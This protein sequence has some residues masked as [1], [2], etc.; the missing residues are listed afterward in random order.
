MDM[1]A[2]SAS[3]TSSLRLKDPA[4]VPASPEI[5]ANASSKLVAGPTTGRLNFSKIFLL[6][7]KG[8]YHTAKYAIL[9]SQLWQLPNHLN[10]AIRMKEVAKLGNAKHI[11]FSAITGFTLTALIRAI[12]R[13]AAKRLP[14][15][16]KN[17]GR[18]LTG[19]ISTT[20]AV[21][22][23][24]FGV[25]RSIGRALTGRA[26]VEHVFNTVRFYIIVVPVAM[27]AMHFNGALQKAIVEAYGSLKNRIKQFGT[28]LFKA[29]STGPTKLEM[30]LSDALPLP[31]APAVLP[32][33]LPK[34]HP[35]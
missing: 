14:A 9:G 35:T 20:M 15:S 16:A 12:D 31:P 10:R 13:Q 33:A 19:I 23:Y 32:G 4:I 3:S 11:F 2:P 27:A 6:T 34:A 8:G 7:L 17:P 22:L 18:F 5:N 30:P 25:D 24:E 28:E 29:T 1:I 21:L 26:V